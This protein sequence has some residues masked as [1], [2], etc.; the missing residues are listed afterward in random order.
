MPT[1]LQSPGE[2]GWR[3]GDAS[4]N[5]GFRALLVFPLATLLLAGCQGAA[6]EGTAAAGANDPAFPPLDSRTIAADRAA[7]QIP[8]ARVLVVYTHPENFLDIRDRVVPS[9]E[10]EKAI[11]SD[12]RAYITK[13]APLYLS[14][15]DFLY[16]NF[17]NIKLAGVYPVGAIG[18]LDRRT[19]LSTTPP[20][21]MFGWAVVDPAGK[22]VGSGTEKL[23]E[24]NFKG[25]FR[26]AD[27]GD[28]L[29]F[30]KAVLDDWMRDRL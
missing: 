4:T 2:K 10:G 29:R 26:S 25:L 28:P 1:Q 5:M 11:L 7:N 30:E 14:G 17:V 20:M 27:T 9:N 21:F 22:I 6:S 13:R 3:L 24:Q 16:V 18:N 8:N 12:L 19:I 15:G 23:E